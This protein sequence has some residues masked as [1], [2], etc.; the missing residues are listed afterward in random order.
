MVDDGQDFAAA[1]IQGLVRG[2]RDRSRVASIW[3]Q[4][5]EFATTVVRGERDERIKR[6][7]ERRAKEKVRKLRGPCVVGTHHKCHYSR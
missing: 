3:R 2:A 6:D 4:A 5:E 1:K 7:A